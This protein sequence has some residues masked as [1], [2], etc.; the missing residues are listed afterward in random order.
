MICC[1][2]TGFGQMPR[3]FALNGD[4]MRLKRPNQLIHIGSSSRQSA[5][6]DEL[7]SR[8]LHQ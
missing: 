2:K 1:G 8:G 4:V 6:P 5:R 3:S 7:L